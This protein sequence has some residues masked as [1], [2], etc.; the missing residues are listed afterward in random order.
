MGESVSATT[1]DT[2]TAPASDLEADGHVHRN[3]HH[4]HGENGAAELARRDNGGIDR[5]AVLLF[6]V[7]IDILDD[8][9]GVIDHESNGQHQRQQRQ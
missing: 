4:G 3:Q 8:D 5:R 2:A 7:P 9:D 1:P 6:H